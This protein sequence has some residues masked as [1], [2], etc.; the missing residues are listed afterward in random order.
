[1]YPKHHRVINHGSMLVNIYHN[2]IHGLFMDNDP[3][4]GGCSTELS[5]MATIETTMYWW[6]T[7]TCWLSLGLW[8]STYLI[9]TN[10]YNW[11]KNSN[12]R[13]CLPV[14]N[15]RHS[16]LECQ[17]WSQNLTRKKLRGLSHLNHDR[18]S[19]ERSFHDPGNQAW[20]SSIG[21][22]HVAIYST[23]TLHVR[24]KSNKKWANQ[25]NRK[26]MHVN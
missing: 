3:L 19:C 2:Y 18:L 20:F 9:L 6:I 7:K 12:S 11:W 25:I 4:V 23:T 16:V 1:M 21:P 24:K 5:C 22:K 10:S 26:W 17:R 15:K 8:V 14:Y 13:S